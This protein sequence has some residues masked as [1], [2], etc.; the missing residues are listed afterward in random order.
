MTLCKKLFQGNWKK[1]SKQLSKTLCSR[2]SC[3]IRTPA[4]TAPPSSFE[5][6][7][8]WS[9][10]VFLPSSFASTVVVTSAGILG[11]VQLVS[12]DLVC[13]TSSELDSFKGPS[14]SGSSFTGPKMAIKASRPPTSAPSSL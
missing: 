11:R 3:F 12:P 9:S 1:R 5:D 6:A 14:E 13:G 2:N 7:C 8:F 4:G 10:S